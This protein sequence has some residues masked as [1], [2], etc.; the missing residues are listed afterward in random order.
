ML[1]F[2]GRICICHL[3][4]RLPDLFQAMRANRIEPKRIRFVQE[5]ANKAPWLILVEGKLGAKPFLQVE[6]PLL[7]WEG[8]NNSKEMLEIFHLYNK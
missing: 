2:G 1:R 4:E 6:R 7:I 5:E 3:P 8:S